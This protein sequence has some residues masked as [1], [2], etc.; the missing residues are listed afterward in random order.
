MNQH[1]VNF[2]SVKQMMDSRYIVFLAVKLQPGVCS[3]ISFNWHA[4]YVRRVTRNPIFAGKHNLEYTWHRTGI[5]LHRHIDVNL[6]ILQNSTRICFPPKLI[7]DAWLP[8]LNNAGDLASALTDESYF[9]ILP[10]ARHKQ[11]LSF[12]V[13]NL[14]Q[15]ISLTHGQVWMPSWAQLGRA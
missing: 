4:D 8:T 13:C 7:I 6:V 12:C 5:C 1:P 15:L 14:W 2:I 9:H 3:E 11:S 10:S